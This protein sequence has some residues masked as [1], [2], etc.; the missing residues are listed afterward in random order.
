LREQV[1]H[2]VQRQS[3][4]L[5]TFKERSHPI[6]GLFRQFFQSDFAVA[7][8]IHA[9]ELFFR[10]PPR[11]SRSGRSR[12]TTKLPRYAA[13]FLGGQF[14][15]ADSLKRASQSF[16]QRFR[17]F[18]LLKLAVTVAIEPLEELALFTWTARCT[19]CELLASPFQIFRR[20]CILVEPFQQ[21]RQKS[22]GAF[23][24]D[25]ILGQLSVFVFVEPFDHLLRINHRPTTKRA[26]PTWPAADFATLH[27]SVTALQRR[28]K[29]GLGQFAIIVAV[30]QPHEA[31][32]KSPLLVRNLVR[33]QFP[34]AIL[35]QPFEQLVGLIGRGFL[36]VFVIGKCRTCRQRQR[37]SDAQGPKIDAFHCGGPDEREIVMCPRSARAY[38][39]STHNSRGSF[40]RFVSFARMSKTGV[41][42]W[43]PHSPRPAERP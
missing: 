32:E 11:T 34:I 33:G 23:V 39:H 27:R 14:V 1:L 35:V 37:A 29:F 8:G 20:E 4:L 31:I 41:A 2:V 12:K 36:H 26:W 5:R 13:E 16:P 15:F 30:S 17:Q 42:D 7:V 9:F 21:L 38:V 10:I 6:A 25:L 22:G 18:V 3:V 43:P 24:W 28:I 40:A 19:T